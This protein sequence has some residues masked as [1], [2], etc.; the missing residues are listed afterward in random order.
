MGT[1]WIVGL[2]TILMGAFLMAMGNSSRGRM[3]GQYRK[4]KGTVAGPVW[5]LLM[6]FGVVIIVIGTVSGV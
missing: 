6:V 2:L 5:F 1:F 4:A 3:G